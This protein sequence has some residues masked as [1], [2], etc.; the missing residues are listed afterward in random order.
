MSDFRPC[1]D[2][3]NWNK[4]LL[5]LNEREWFGYQHVTDKYCPFHVF[6]LVKYEEV[7][8]G[9]GWPTA[10]EAL[11]G[12]SKVTKAQG[13]FVQVSEAF[14]EIGPRIDNAR[15]KGDLLREE[16][17]RR[18]QVEHLSETSKEVM[19]Y[20]TGRSPKKTP[21]T[22]WLAKKRKREGR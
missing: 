15:V 21:F 22:T 1:R 2:C 19:A 6:W 4:C 3:K 17:K 12:M 11:G 20:V 14:A 16:C 13:N 5:T 18:E 7:L 9:F 8:R 10:E